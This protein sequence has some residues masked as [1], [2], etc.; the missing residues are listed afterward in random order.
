MNG[1]VFFIVNTFKQSI[2]N[3]IKFNDFPVKTNVCTY[4]L[5]FTRHHIYIF[6]LL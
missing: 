3:I 1:K 2:K 5:Y 4:F 6:I